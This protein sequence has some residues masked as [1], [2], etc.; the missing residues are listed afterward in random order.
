VTTSWRAGRGSVVVGA[1][2]WGWR[3][4]RVPS[5]WSVGDP[6][7]QVRPGVVGFTIGTPVGMSRVARCG[8][9]GAGWENYRPG[10]CV[11]SGSS[12][13]PDLHEHVTSGAGQLSC[14]H[15][16]TKGPQDSCVGTRQ[17][18]SRRERACP[19]AG[20]GRHATTGFRSFRQTGHPLIDGGGERVDYTGGRWRCASGVRRGV[21]GTARQAAPCMIRSTHGSRDRVEHPWCRHDHEIGGAAGDDRCEVRLSALG[22]AFH[23]HLAWIVR[24]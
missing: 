20:D 7:L 24:R 2:W 15:P 11:A 5:R 18:R 22:R 17:G 21:S 6:S 1:S 23:L 10:G 13:L 12:C 9:A 3:D 14:G 4:S 19:R 8:M 16:A